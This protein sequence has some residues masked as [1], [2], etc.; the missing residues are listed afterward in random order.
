LCTL[1]AIRHAADPEPLIACGRWAGEL[2]VAARGEG[3]F[4]YDP[5]LFIAGQGCCVGEMSAAVK[6]ALSHRAIAMRQMRELMVEV[7]RLRAV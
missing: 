5:L 6:N 7:W 3:G 1:V 2:L 4:G